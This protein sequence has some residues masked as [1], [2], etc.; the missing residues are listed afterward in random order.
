MAVQLDN[1]TT[2]ILMTP[3]LLLV[4]TPSITV[5]SL[6]GFHFLDN[7][8]EKRFGPDNGYA[9]VRRDTV[10]DQLSACFRVFVRFDRYGGRSIFHNSN[11]FL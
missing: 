8:L 6:T 7:K 9:T 4:M 1:R 10:P 5:L 11:K 2:F 3:L